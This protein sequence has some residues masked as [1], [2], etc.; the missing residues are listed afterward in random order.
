MV[1]IHAP[2]LIYDIL[3]SASPEGG[4]KWPWLEAHAE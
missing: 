1:S 3:V 4:E 2:D